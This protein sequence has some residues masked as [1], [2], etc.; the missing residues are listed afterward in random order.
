M[1]AGEQKYVSYFL[2]LYS[3][4]RRLMSPWAWTAS[5]TTAPATRQALLA[6]SLAMVGKQENDPGMLVQAAKLYGRALKEAAADLESPAKGTSDG[7]LAT[8][9]MM[10]LYEV[11]SFRLP[12][13]IRE[14]QDLR[15]WTL[16]V[17]QRC[18]QPS[19]LVRDTV[20]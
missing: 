20:S 10:R 15:M 19:R 6:L 11:R 17:S 13:S 9:T 16:D 5:R 12:E 2:D 14:V 3:P 1:T 4:G 8:V 18:R 7:T